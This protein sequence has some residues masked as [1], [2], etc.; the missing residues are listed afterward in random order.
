MAEK[1]L[2]ELDHPQQEVRATI[3]KFRLHDEANLIKQHA[4]HHDESQLIQSVKAAAA[5]LEELFEMDN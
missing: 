5:E 4:I 1:V 3:E 2:C